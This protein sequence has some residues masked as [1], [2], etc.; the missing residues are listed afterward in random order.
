MVTGKPAFSA[1]SRAS[2]IAAILTTDPSPISQLQ[3]L[4]PLALERVVKKCLAKDPDE[5]WQ[6]AGDLATELKWISESGSQ[7][8]AAVP[9]AN[10]RFRGNRLAWGVAAAALV[11]ALVI[12]VVHLGE[13]SKPVRVVR[14]L[15][16][17][18]EG[19]FPI[20]TGDFA[21]PPALSQNGK[22]VVFVAARGQGAPSLWVRPLNDLHARALSGTEGASF[23]FWSAD[24]RSLGFFA[25][26]RLKTVPIEGGTPSELCEAPSG[27][28]GTWSSQ[29]TIV[30]APGFQTALMQVPAAGG[31][32]KPAT[33]MDSSK[34]DSHRWP[35]F[36]P[37]GKHFLYL[38]VT[39]GSNRD[40]NDAIYLSSLDGK[41]NRLLMRTTT[42]VAYA[43]G[44]LLFMRGAELVAQPFD[45]K[46][47]ELQGEP[48]RVAEDVLVDGTVWR[49]QFTA[50]NDGILAYA[51][52]GLTPWQ[53]MW[54]DRS[55]KEVGAAGEKVANLVNVR[56]SPD[57]SRLA[58][59]AGDADSDIWIYDPKRQVN[60]RLTFGPGASTSPVW[61]PDGHW[62]AYMG[63]RGKNNVYRR[64]VSG[65]GQEELLLEGDSTNRNPLD[66]SAD[67]KFLLIGVGDL[68]STGRIW[69]LS[70]AGDRK[71]VPVTQSAFQAI[72]AKF[73][74]DGH[75]LAYSSNES[76]RQEVYVMPFGSGTGKWQ[77][78]SSG[79]T[80]PVWRR[81]GKELFY[82]STDNNLMSVPI[83]LKP[84]LVEVGAAHPLF[85][86]NN[87]VG[88]IGVVSPYD[89]TTD[90]QRFVLITTPQQTPRPVTLV[91]NWMADLKQ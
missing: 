90:G 50:S 27:R 41:E 80:Q 68:S 4:T 10:A 8:G 14:S 89:V 3:P 40:A 32:P 7:A 74:P 72:S 83:T 70:L 73:S 39:H 62:I 57:G 42:N 6:S 33:V 84:G 53:A 76:G 2:L 25:A 77:I 36:L 91:T 30:F 51:S 17:V 61:S 66:W 26:G 22:L 88:V 37:D 35:Y 18:E 19:T 87:P 38:A 58:T 67:G 29:G 24:D 13:G 63:V 45:P 65:V 69:V 52:G 43:S 44:H 31:T 81:D 11:A 15:I 71:A 48:E 82:W 78:S 20:F 21:G 12:A 56:L 47:G 64:P 86:F 85:R 79:G 16:A 28:G 1:K 5:R 46:K 60:T 75:W 9:N 34:H 49:A 23:P 54:Y 59:E 55:G